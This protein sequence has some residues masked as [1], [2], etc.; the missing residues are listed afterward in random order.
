MYSDTPS[1][2]ILISSCLLIVYVTANGIFNWQGIMVGPKDSSFV[3]GLFLVIF[4][5][6]IQYL[7][8]PIKVV[9]SRALDITII[10]HFIYLILLCLLFS[11]KVSF[12]MKLVFHL[13]ICIG[14]ISFNLL[15]TN[16]AL[17]LT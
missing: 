13:N 6:G 8:T 3:G 14:G 11:V 2:C 17:E 16:G 4:R 12:K 7:T 9:D 15:S 1:I 10:C 5:F